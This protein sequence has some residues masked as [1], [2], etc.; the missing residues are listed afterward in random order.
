MPRSLGSKNK[1]TERMQ[2]LEKQLTDQRAQNEMIRQ[3]L[4]KMQKQSLSQQHSPLDTDPT[5][6]PST[7]EKIAKHPRF[8][9]R[10]FKIREDRQYTAWASGEIASA[11][12]YQKQF[13]VEVV[14]HAQSQFETKTFTED[15]SKRCR[16]SG[17]YYPPSPLTLSTKPEP[18]HHYRKPIFIWRPDISFEIPQI[19]CTANTC[20]GKLRSHGLYSNGPLKFVSLKDVG[21]IVSWS[22]R[23][24]SCSRQL[25][26]WSEEFLKILPSHVQQ[27]F[28]FALHKTSAIYH[29]I[30]ELIS[31]QFRDLRVTEIVRLIAEYHSSKYLQ[32]YV[33][34]LQRCAAYK[35]QFS[36]QQ[37]LIPLETAISFAKFSK[38]EDSGGYDGLRSIDCAD[39]V[40]SYL[41]AENEYNDIVQRR[42]V[43]E[44]IL[45][46]D[47]SNTFN[48]VCYF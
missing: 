6:K 35:K 34:Y 38:L 12:R 3:E 29:E 31:L 11:S 44:K 33:L 46:A 10:I 39:I 26:G 43:G 8:S 48:T 27:W 24:S 37:N 20:N 18:F 28:P 2:L 15:H 16:G 41:E 45:C 36:N 13:L 21:Y 19:S 22:Y 5:T 25:C 7:S 47:Y 9:E 4:A 30:I 42:I 17:F 23:C 40:K 1:N 14:H 32:E